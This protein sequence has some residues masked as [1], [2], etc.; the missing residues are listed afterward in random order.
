MSNRLVLCRHPEYGACYLDKAS[1]E[2]SKNGVR[3]I[4]PYV[5]VINRRTQRI[6]LFQRKTGDPR[7]V[8]GYIIG[9]GGHVELD[10]A[11]GSPFDVDATL[12][13]AAVREIHEEICC[14]C[15]S[16]SL[17]KMICTEIELS[18]NEVNSAHLGVA[19]IFYTSARSMKNV[20][21]DELE[22]IGWKTKSELKEYE[23][24]AWSEFVMENAL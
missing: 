19:Y 10:D 9:I 3:Q 15:R 21:A 22:F 4:I 1:T 7:L 24:E 2:K 6:A 5:I 16:V 11:E 13:S 20:P 23:L 14:S 8:G 12:Y 17:Y 18:D